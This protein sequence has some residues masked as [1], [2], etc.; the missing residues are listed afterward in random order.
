VNHYT[1]EFKVRAVKPTWIGKYHRPKQVEKK[2]GEEYLYEE[3]KRLKKEN[4]R[5]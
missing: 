1:A 2:V 3:L 5:L 4:A